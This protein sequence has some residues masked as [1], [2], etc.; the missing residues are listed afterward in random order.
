MFFI[1]CQS[2]QREREGERG[3]ESEG[4]RER[5][6]ERGRESERG[7][8]GERETETERARDR[9]RESERKRQRETEQDIKYILK[10]IKTSERVSY[11]HSQGRKASIPLFHFPFLQSPPYYSIWGN[12]ILLILT[13][14][15]KTKWGTLFIESFFFCNKNFSILHTAYWRDKNILSQLLKWRTATQYILIWATNDS[16]R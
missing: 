1:K 2:V 3:R 9:D 8:E 5:E 16:K 12:P 13:H 15:F 10:Q 6:G 11:Q 14:P 4:G 7:R